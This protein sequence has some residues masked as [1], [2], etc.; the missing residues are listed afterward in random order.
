MRSPR[1]FLTLGLILM[2]V[3]FIL[4]TLMVMRIL[5]RGF[6]RSFV[7][8]AASVSGIF[9]GVIAVAMMTRTR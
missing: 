3:G 9:L 5:P 2:L 8:W 7:S 1:L 6:F 4:P